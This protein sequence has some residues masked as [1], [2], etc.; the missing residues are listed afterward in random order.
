[1]YFTV[2]VNAERRHLT[3][4]QKA[5]A[6][7]IG[8]MDAGMRGN[9]RWKRGSV[10]TG[11]RSSAHAWAQQVSAAGVILDHVPE[12]A[13]S[14]LDGAAALD[15]AWKQAVDVRDRTKRLAEVG[16]DL[17]ILVADGVLTLE[18]AEQRVADEL[19]IAGLAA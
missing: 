10:P 18:D 16:P 15:A 7:A 8:L 6:V 9:G 12:L 2:E 13:D 14:V 17:A 11:A 19:R 4:G 5:M 1:V 3:T